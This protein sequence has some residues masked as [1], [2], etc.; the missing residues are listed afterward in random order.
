MEK[1]A[2]KYAELLLKVPHRITG[3][4]QGNYAQNA[5]EIVKYA[6]ARITADWWDDFETNKEGVFC[7]E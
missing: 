4:G 5:T 1:E 7:V 2:E 6:A 3:I